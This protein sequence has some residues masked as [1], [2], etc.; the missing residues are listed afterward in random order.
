M[1]GR[2]A[3]SRLFQLAEGRPCERLDVLLLVNRNYVQEPVLSEIA[4]YQQ[5]PGTGMLGTNAGRC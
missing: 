2:S 4:C 3:H 5:L 1:K